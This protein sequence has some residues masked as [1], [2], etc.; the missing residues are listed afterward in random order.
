MMQHF[1]RL[2]R[3]FEPITR[4]YAYLDDSDYRADQL[5][6]DHGI[7]VKF[8]A[9]FSKRNGDYHFVV[10]KVPFWRTKQTEE[11]METL[12]NKMIILH[13][14]D[15]LEELRLIQPKTQTT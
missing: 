10:I 5:F 7:K 15:Y 4:M 12:Y 6:K 2:F 8:C 9:T 13:R 1:I 11:C 14:N 3:K